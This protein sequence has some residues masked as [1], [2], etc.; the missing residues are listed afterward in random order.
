MKETYEAMK[1]CVGA[2]NYSKH[3]WKICADLT[4]ISLLVEMQ[5]G[6]TKYMCFLCLWYSWDDTNHFRKTWK[7][8]KNLTVGKFNLKHTPPVNS[9]NIL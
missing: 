8:F 6:Y 7:P 9:K 1:T 5:L 2:I 4:I 3:N